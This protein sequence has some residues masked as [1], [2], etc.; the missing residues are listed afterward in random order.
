MQQC[1]LQFGINREYIDE[2]LLDVI[3]LYIYGI[4]LESLYLWDKDA[5][6][7]RKENKY[8]LIKD[9]VKYM[10]CAYKKS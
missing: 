1:Q 7:Y 10:V 6:F 5:L 8:R 2:I 9:G 4:V 3:P